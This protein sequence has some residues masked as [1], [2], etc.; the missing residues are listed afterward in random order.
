MPAQK[1]SGKLIKRVTQIHGMGCGVACVAAVLGIRYDV[2]LRLFKKPQN[3]WTKGFMCRDLVKA[4]NKAGFPYQHKY[5][6]NK[7]DLILR[8]PG[9]IVFTRFSRAYP[10]GHYLVRTRKGWMNPWANF[11]K[12]APAKS[13]IVARLPAQPSYAVFLDV[14]KKLF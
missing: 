13:A 12:I 6:K 1:R 8:V 10:R 2:A 14:Q 7:R 4:L 11:P 9:T 3:A 5:L